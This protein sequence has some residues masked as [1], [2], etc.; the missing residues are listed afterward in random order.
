MTVGKKREFNGDLCFFSCLQKQLLYSC[1]VQNVI[2]HCG[3]KKQ[4]P[5]GIRKFT[6]V[7]TV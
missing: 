4:L 6:P 7:E 2:T 1:A 3:R 5:Q